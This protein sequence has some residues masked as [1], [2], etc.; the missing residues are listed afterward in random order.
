MV[1]VSA[2]H[3]CVCWHAIAVRHV[4]V[5]LARPQPDWRRRPTAAPS[6]TPMRTTGSPWNT[7]ARWA[8]SARENSAKA[9]ERR[10]GPDRC[11]RRAPWSTR[12]HGRTLPAFAAAVTR[13]CAA[14]QTHVPCRQAWRCSARHGNNSR[15]R[16]ACKKKNASPPRQTKRQRML[17]SALGYVAKF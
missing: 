17:Q 1:A 9:S 13:D 2:S 16:A 12:G 10:T 6:T 4:N 8:T 3:D 15:R 11:H 5:N 7:W 14:Q